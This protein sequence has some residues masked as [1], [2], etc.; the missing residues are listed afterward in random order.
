MIGFVRRAASLAALIVCGVFGA[1]ALAGAVV[2]MSRAVADNVPLPAWLLQTLWFAAAVVQ[3]AGRSDKLTPH[4]AR[5][6]THY[7]LAYAASVAALMSLFERPM[8]GAVSLVSFALYYVCVTRLVDHFFESTDAAAAVDAKQPPRKKQLVAIEGN[9]GA[10]KT[11][12][13]TALYKFL[14]ERITTKFESVPEALHAA[15]VA[16]PKQFAYALQMVMAERRRNDWRQSRLTASVAGRVFCDRTC[17]GDMAF[18][19]ANYVLGRIDERQFA[20]YL[21][22]MGA[23]PSEAMGTTDGASVVLLYAHTPVNECRLRIAK[24]KL[25]D[26][27]V[28]VD[29]LHMLSVAHLLCLL[30]VAHYSKDVRIVLFDGRERAPQDKA[31]AISFVKALG[32]K[33]NASLY[34]G[35]AERKKAAAAAVAAAPPLRLSAEQGER[36]EKLADKWTRGRGY[37]RTRRLRKCADGGGDEAAYQVDES[38]WYKLVSGVVDERALVNETKKRV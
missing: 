32:G 15:F 7:A 31:S 1:S 36:L 21:E 29:Y 16:E 25:V 38:V 6:A 28:D 14:E 26:S 22:S 35:A 37:P 18:A 33:P 11:T 5:Y 17:F 24:R 13:L 8:L 12:L 2:K 10:G 3:M 9:I 34:S 23:T 27:D 4:L 30:Q 19:V 20:V